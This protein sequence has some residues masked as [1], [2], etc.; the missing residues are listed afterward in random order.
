MTTE[1]VLW[2]RLDT[3]GHDACR[4]EK[5][6]FGWRLEGMAVFR[7]RGGAAQLTYH[8]MCDHEWRSLSGR[9]L[10]WLDQQSIDFNIAR[11][12]EGLWTLNGEVVAGLESCVDLDFG[13]TPATNLFQL[14]RLALT[15]GRAADAPGAWLDVASGILSVLPQRYERR[16]E[17]I[18]WY[19]ATS[20]NYAAELEVAPIGFIRRYPGL[21]EMEP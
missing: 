1:S 2:R 9:V 4:L 6:D 14:R 5:K 16:T 18:Y 13:F 15:P 17:T 8:A 12:T 21:W 3:P 11:T 19:E 20:V 10:G 7:Q